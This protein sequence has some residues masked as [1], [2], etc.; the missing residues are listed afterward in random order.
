MA[1]ILFPLSFLALIA[2]A[3]FVLVRSVA[4]SWER[5]VAALDGRLIA[6]PAAERV[7]GVTVRKPIDLPYVARRMGRT[8]G[9]DPARPVAP[10][11]R[12]AA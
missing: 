2:L 10:G 9:T 8:V 5:I 12:K 3:S 11:K 7:L 4:D 6:R 1:E